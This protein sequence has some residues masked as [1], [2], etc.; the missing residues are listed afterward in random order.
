MLAPIDVAGLEEARAASMLAQSA[1]EAHPWLG[2]TM[3]FS[4]PG[5]WQNQVMGAGLERLAAT[6]EIDAMVAFYESRGVEARIEICP[7]IH[8]SLLQGL[9]TRLFTIREL[10]NV[11]FLELASFGST[12]EHE[13]PHGVEIAMVDSSEATAV[14]ELVEVSLRGFFPA[15][16]PIP[17]PSSDASRSVLAMPRTRGFIAKLEGRAV[18]GGLL[19]LG[20][21]AA[22]LA[23]TSVLPE[24]RRRGIQRALMLARLQAARAHGCRIATIDSK[25]GIPTERNAMRLGFTMAYTKMVLARAGTGLEPSP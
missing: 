14:E 3:G 25:P 15:G 13:T 16:E 10:E 1:R 20:E 8:E 18:G 12:D 2:G 7:F 17:E 19:D 9:S 22:N 24:Y 6:S 21:G 5:S 23:G 4:G 11:L